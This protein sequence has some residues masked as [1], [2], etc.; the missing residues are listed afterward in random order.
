VVR[1]TRPATEPIEGMEI[2]GGMY[3]CVH[4]PDRQ[5]M[6]KANALTHV[7]GH[8]QNGVTMK[9]SAPSIDDVITG[10]LQMV[11]KLQLIKAND[12]NK[13]KAD[14]WDELLRLVNR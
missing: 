5:Y 13:V 14:N 6:R 2:K 11:E 4:C 12:V 3:H 9:S 8:I 7:N 10:L 1:R